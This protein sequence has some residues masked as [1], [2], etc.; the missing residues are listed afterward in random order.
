MFPADLD[1]TGFDAVV[2]TFIHTAPENRP[3]LHEA[4]VDRLAPGGVVVLEAF[5]PEQL[6]YSS[7]GP[8]NPAMLY[9]P[10][11]LAEDFSRLDLAVL[12]ARE[13]VHD[14][15]PGHRGTAAVVRLFGRRDDS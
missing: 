7:G 5:T 9:T 1:A 6:A 12:E 8:R 10:A 13:V 14:E 2:L 11:Q 3:G 4:V 15:G